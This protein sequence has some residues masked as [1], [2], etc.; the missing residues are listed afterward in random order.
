MV[1]EMMKFNVRKQKNGLKSKRRTKRKTEEG[2]NSKQNYAQNNDSQQGKQ[3]QCAA[4]TLPNS[5]RMGIQR[6]ARGGMLALLLEVDCAH[7]LYTDD[8]SLQLLLLMLGEGASSQE[9]TITT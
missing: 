5:R 8:L 7:N 4:F 3:K 2:W 9:M 1:V 6:S